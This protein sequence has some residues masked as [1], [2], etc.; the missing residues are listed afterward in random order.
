[1]EWR[2][3]ECDRNYDEPPPTCV[4]GS[5]NVEPR[6]DRG[7]GRFSLLELR[8]RLLEPADADRSLVRD[9]P[10]VTVAFR[11]LFVL[12]IGLAVLLLAVWLLS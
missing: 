5:A 12:A 2:C 1:M 7:S 6:D 10:Y 11:V 8:R 3:A 4:C 9:E